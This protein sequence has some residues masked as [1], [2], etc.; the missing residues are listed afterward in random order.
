MGFQN[1]CVFTDQEMVIGYI[2]VISHMEI[3]VT[4]FL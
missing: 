3:L 2:S 1:L 4:K